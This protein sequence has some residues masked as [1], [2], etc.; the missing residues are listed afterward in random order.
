MDGALEV[1]SFV[2]VLTV[3]DLMLRLHSN[4]FNQKE[5]QFIVVFNV[6]LQHVFTTYVY[7]ATV[8]LTQKHKWLQSE[9]FQKW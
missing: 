2:L 3:Q 8:K 5:H 4:I 9:A 1:Y 7:M 6:C